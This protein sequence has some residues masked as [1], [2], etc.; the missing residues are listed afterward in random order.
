[1]NEPT[2]RS[3]EIRDWAIVLGA[4]AV[5]AAICIGGVTFLTHV[6]GPRLFTHYGDFAQMADMPKR[7]VSARGVIGDAIN[8][9]LIGS[10]AE[11]TKAFADAHWS[12]AVPITRASSVGIAKSVI[13]NRPDSAAP[14]SPLFLFGRLQDHAF[15]LEEGR[16][17]RRRHHIRLW[18][19][20]GI[21]YGGREVWIGGASFDASA[22]MSHRD[23]LPTHHIDP[24]I[25]KERDY[26]D[27]VLAHAGQVERAFHVTGVGVRVDARN[28]EG[29]RFD[30]DGELTVLVIPVGNLPHAV[31]KLEPDPLL[32]RMKT[33]FWERWHRRSG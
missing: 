29:D 17:A 12:E 2:N 15:E 19:A 27:S 32:V 4:G 14:V 18:R 23:L 9:A 25:D 3:R 6:V 26:V 28:A 13:F 22:G 10:E 33:S 21:T 11:V 20:N 1:M 31:P 16:S 7:Q 5:I 30:T 24:D 8:L